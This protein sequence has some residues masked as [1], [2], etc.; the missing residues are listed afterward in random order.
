MVAAYVCDI[1]IPSIDDG[2]EGTSLVLEISRRLVM[3]RWQSNAED[4]VADGGWIVALSLFLAVS[5]NGEI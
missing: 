5:P 4:G 2:G 3:E 1:D